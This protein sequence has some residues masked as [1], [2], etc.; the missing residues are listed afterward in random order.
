MMQASGTAT[1]PRRE[2]NWPPMGLS[3][4]RVGQRVS[5][6]PSAAGRARSAIG[7]N[8]AGEFRYDNLPTNETTGKSVAR[9]TGMRL[10]PDA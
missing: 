4:F 5:L 3:S 9:A 6:L 8:S 7:D 2:G 1:K 10:N